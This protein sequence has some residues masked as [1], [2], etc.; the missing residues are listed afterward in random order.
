MRTY[1][2]EEALQSLASS[3]GSGRQLVS[4]ALFG[5][6]LTGRF[7]AKVAALPGGDLDLLHA[8]VAGLKEM[9]RNGLISAPAMGGHKF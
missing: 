7:G 5:A 4:P 8:C 2:G 3:F 6:V 1:T 9:S